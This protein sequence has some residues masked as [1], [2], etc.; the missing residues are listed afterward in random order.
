M[1]ASLK[2]LQIDKFEGHSSINTGVNGEDVDTQMR[3]NGLLLKDF[4]KI[5][6]KQNSK[7]TSNL[8]A[9]ICGICQICDPLH[10]LLVVM[11]N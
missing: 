10:C 6:Q 8:I 9:G 4:D 5:S 1:G 3:S 7:D 2:S 11:L